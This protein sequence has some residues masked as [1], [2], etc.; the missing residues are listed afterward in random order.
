MILLT[1]SW[2]KKSRKPQNAKASGGQ[3]SKFPNFPIYL[4]A[5]AQPCKTP[6]SR[7][8]ARY[9]FPFILIEFEQIAIKSLV[10]YFE[11]ECF[12]LSLDWTQNGLLEKVKCQTMEGNLLKGDDFTMV[13]RSHFWG[14][15]VR[16]RN[17]FD[18]LLI[19]FFLRT[20]KGE[21]DIWAP[22]GFPVL[23]RDLYYCENN[24]GTENK[25][26]RGSKI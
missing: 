19:S 9:R 24:C 25:P 3:I 22:F 14:S 2:N 12:Y 11:E 6:S 4:C 17:Q 7:S 10:P 16:E 5:I 15:G 26:F 8:L 20:W 1:G 21:I 18:F 23:S 13:K